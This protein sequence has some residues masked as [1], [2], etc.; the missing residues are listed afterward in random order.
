MSDHSDI[1]EALVRA[2][3]D[4][5]SSEK[6][7]LDSEDREMIVKYHLGQITRTELD[8]FAL[9]KAKRIHEQGKRPQ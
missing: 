5:A 1:K 6:G 8:R 4:A 7:T 9:A 2:I 3:V